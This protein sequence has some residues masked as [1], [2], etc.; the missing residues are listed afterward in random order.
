LLGVRYEMTENTLL[1]NKNKP[2]GK[3]SCYFA[4][5]FKTLNRIILVVHRQQKAL[6]IKAFLLFC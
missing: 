5:R 3:K 4:E 1:I 6:C 2:F